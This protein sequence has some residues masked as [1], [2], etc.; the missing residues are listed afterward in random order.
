LVRHDGRRPQR[1]IVW[2]WKK[3]IKQGE[4]GRHIGTT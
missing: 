4:D 3:K 2:E 1:A